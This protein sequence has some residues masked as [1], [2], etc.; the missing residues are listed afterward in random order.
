MGIA[1]EEQSTGGKN[2]KPHGRPRPKTAIIHV[3]AMFGAGRGGNRLR[4]VWRHPKA[5][6]HRGQWQGQGKASR[7]VLQRHG[8]RVA[9]NRP[10]GT[11]ARRQ[12]RHKRGVHDILRQSR[13]GP[14]GGA[15]R[16]HAKNFNL[17]PVAGFRPRN[18]N[19]A[20][21][22]VGA[23]G[24]LDARFVP[25]IGVNGLGRDRIAAV[26]RQGGRQSGQNVVI[27]A[28]DEMM[29]GH[30]ATLARMRRSGKHLTLAAFFHPA[31]AGLVQLGAN[32]VRR[33]KS[34]GSHEHARQFRR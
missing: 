1:E 34:R 6:D 26:H 12:V 16:L 24:D 19:R 3:A 20:V 11:G 21:H 4:A 28:G 17:Q 7:R 18:R 10:G 27:L 29:A 2:R 5:A 8:S 22:R 13:T 33:A 23:M 25:A 14:A 32:R 15:V 31:A 30:G 9:V